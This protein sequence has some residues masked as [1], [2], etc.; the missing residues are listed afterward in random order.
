MRQ[1][2]DTTRQAAIAGPA[3]ARE[4]A[5]RVSR[6]RGNWAVVAAVVVSLLIGV[7]TV[8]AVAQLYKH[9]AATDASVSAL[10]QLAEQG[11]TA[12]QQANATL[13]KRGQAT[14][15]IP[16]PGSADDTDVLVAAATAK[17]LAAL[18]DL[19]PTATEL[20][21][22][23][24]AYFAANPVIPA[25]PTPTQI[26]AALAGYFTTNPPPSG[27]SGADGAQGDTGATG[28]TGP[29]GPAPTEAQIQAAFA[30]YVKANPDA[31]CPN[32]GQFELVSSI[33]A[34]D[35]TTYSGW[36]CVT[37]SQPPVVPTTSTT[38]TDPGL[39]PLLGH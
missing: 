27:P 33:L 19:R 20:G 2:A 30:D 21:A 28:A 12:G 14:V 3:A 4:V 11:F 8:L 5:E 23:V 25:G 37:A 29:A 17:V 16:Q 36:M 38:T 18:P 39:L 15:P 6:R 22:Q 24:A 7:S 26:S 31:L 35:G 9:Q 1:L 34:T 13:A 32:G 10:R